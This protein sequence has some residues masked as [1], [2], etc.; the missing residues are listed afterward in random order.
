[1]KLNNISAVFIKQLQDT[2]KNK[3]VLIQYIMLPVMALIMTGTIQSND[4]PENFF[5]TLFATMY[6]GMAPLTS[7]TS[8]IAEE[9]ETNTLR[10]L[11]LSDVRPLEYLIG[12]GAN[13]FMNCLAGSIVFGLI[14][15]YSPLILLQ[16][17]GSMC[18]GIL[19]SIIIGAVIGIVCKSQMNAVSVSIPVMMIFAFLPMI[20]SFNDKIMPVSRL[21]Y[22]QQ[23]N[24]LINRAGHMTFEWEN[25]L[26]I[27]AN[28]IISAVLFIY[29]YRK[30]GLA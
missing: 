14:G 25:V 16:F 29:V 28:I 15:K 7:M 5:V 12:V 11:L 18:I 8:I 22:S 2:L 30:K 24:D 27:V 26:V 10:V 19:T 1:M 13:V 17:T 4:M 21:T 3:T 23:I 9:K 6:I 20:A